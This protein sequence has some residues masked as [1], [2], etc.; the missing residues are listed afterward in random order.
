[1][2]KSRF[3]YGASAAVIALAASTA[4]FAQETTGGISGQ[5]VD[6]N[7]A[8]V[9]GATVTV[10]HQPS[11]TTSTT[12]T[13][14]SGLYGTR[15]L[16]V[17]GPYVVTVS[18]PAGERTSVVP[19]IGIGA[20]ASLDI[21]LFDND[22][23]TELEEIVVTGARGRRPTSPRANFNLGDIE[24]LPSISRDIKDFVR[25]SP[26]ATVDPTNVNA[27]SIGGQNTRFNAFLVDG[28]RQGDD[29]G[30]NA[31]GYPTQNSPISISILEAVT[32][33]VAP[34]DVQYGSFTG[35]V[36]NSVTKSGGNEFRGEAFYETTNDGLQGNSFTYDD[37]VT[38]D[39]EER[40]VAGTFEETSWGATLSGPI[41]KDRLFFLVNY[42]FFEATQPVTSGPQGSGATNEV[43]GIT[44]A[45]IDLVRQITQDVYGYDPLDW[46]ADNLLIEDEKW[47]GK[48]DWNISDRH[49]AVLSYQQTEGGDLRL[50]GTSTSSTYPSVGL[51][52]QAYTLQSNLK[53]YK[54]QIFSDWTDTF[55]TELSMSIKEVENI[56]TPL[57]GSDFASFQ[58]YLDDP[59]GPARPPERSIR[60]G[61]DRSRH[62]N[63][64]TVDTNQYRA[65]GNWDVM[66]GHRVTFGYEREETEIFNLFVQV[67][68]AEYEFA[69]IE[70]YRNRIASSVG[71]SNA[72]SNNKN[73]AAASFGYALNTLFAQDTWT[74]TAN[75]TI[76]A[77]LRYDWYEMEDKPLLNP[78]FVD[79]FGFGN[80]STL[81]GISIIQPRIGFNWRP[82]D[83]L[84]IYGGIGRFQGGSPNVWISNSYSNPGNLI[85][86]FNCRISSQY[87]SQ[88]AGGF[89]VCPD[90]S[91]LTNVDGFNPN[92]QLKDRVTESANL[93]T[94]NINLI[95]PDFRT[96]SIWKVSLGVSKAFDLSRWNLGSG[97]NATAEIVHSEL[98]DAIGWVDLNM[99]E[100][101]NGTAPDGRPIFG[102]N[103]SPNSSQNVLMLTNLFGGY[104]TQFAVS[105]S[106]DWYDGWLEGAGFNLSY[107]YLNAKDRSGGTSSTASSNYSNV[108]VSDPNSPPLATSNY[109][110]EDAIKLNIRYDRAFF[111]D[112]LTRF[113]LF[114]QRRSGL[115]F[116]YVYTDSPQTM[117][118]ETYSTRRQLLYVP[119]TGAGGLVTAT[120]DPIV[121]YGANFDFARFNEF[122]QSSGL[123]RYAGG[124]SERNAF[125]SPDVT[126]VDLH[127]EQELPAFF[128]GGARLSMYA[129]IENLGNLLNDEWGVIQ[130]VG[131]PY[132]Y[133]AVNATRGAD[134]Y[135]YNN[136]TDDRAAAS[137]NAQ[138]VWQVK[139]GVRYKF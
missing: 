100:T 109:E 129:D 105:L 3:A 11:G 79:R 32:V 111:G 52:S 37:F 10:V 80:D 27:L 69:S 138:S 99:A 94:G 92:Q 97:W 18:S 12:L 86:S 25:T 77:G 22:S 102:P 36:I 68:N 38:G 83:G 76:T 21:A 87:S 42:E 108:V 93:G 51:L 127:I 63:A 40:T 50:A 44:Q 112:Y 23:A 45:E 132:A 17:G 59:T 89:G 57:A 95:D 98:K 19:A 135:T 16:R 78:A 2:L 82:A 8:P 29:F 35:G 20:P 130:Q 139:F 85:G 64:L 53:T 91:Y 96:P 13:D 46:R 6:A 128:P 116:S 31:N 114:A 119:Q 65:V 56:S 43:A 106:K 123:I 126:T 61:P 125:K 67:A 34:Y 133:Q 33:D 115:P 71:Y 134:F 103:P 121:R 1:M 30:L 74:P 5:V 113:N 104:S 47:F 48:L 117:Y 62:A 24:T 72:A 41:L 26:F 39:T 49:R 110:I 107:T 81:D 55:S 136:F 70:D 75:L 73:D 124:I 14:A 15:N 137:F 54:G 90:A 7:G 66:D 101:E 28:I 122:L 9:A 58:I 84:S 60:L 4:V 118:G 131:F 120:S 88:F